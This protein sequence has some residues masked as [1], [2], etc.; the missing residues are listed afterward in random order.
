MRA[1]YRHLSHR[2]ILNAYKLSTDT[3]Y[4]LQYAIAAAKGYTPDEIFSGDFEGSPLHF[5]TVYNPGRLSVTVV[6]YTD[7]PLRPTLGGGS[8]IDNEERT[9]VHFTEEEGVYP[10]DE[11]VAT[12]L[13][14]EK[15]VKTG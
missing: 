8:Y 4:K 3:L 11:L 13:L 6:I 9:L 14:L 10:S 15:S 2:E 12:I 5:R 7:W 1:R